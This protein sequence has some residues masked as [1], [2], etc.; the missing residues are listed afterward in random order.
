MR[1]LIA[2]IFIV[3][4]SFF[5][6]AQSLNGL[7][8]GSL[9]PPKSS[10]DKGLLI[11][12]QINEDKSG[13]ITGKVRN[14]RF[15]TNDFALK[16]IKGNKKALDVTINETV[17]SQKAVGS[18]TTWCRLD[19]TLKYNPETGYLVGTYASSDCRNQVGNVILYR[20][21]VAFPGDKDNPESQHWF[22]LL[23]Q[24]I[25]KGLNAPEIRKIE[26]DNFVF[27]PIYFEYDKAEIKP[28]FYDFLN[29]LVKIV[30]GHSDLRVKVT[31]HTD[32]DGSDKYNDELSKRRAQA[33]IDFFVARGLKADRLEFDFNGEHKPVDSNNTPE[34][35]QKNRRVEFSFI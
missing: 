1:V 25:S 28:E 22:E 26:R 5:T 14:E 20:D 6:T 15:N 3:G 10:V 33:I 13:A 8:K 34:G 4:W 19:L 2:F 9:Y 21:P 30:E 12:L 18:R 27:Q 32:S 23:A 16:N 35:R 11:Y 24:D 17:I 31:G 29:H 7:W